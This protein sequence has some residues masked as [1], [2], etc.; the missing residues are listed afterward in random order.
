VAAEWN[1]TVKRGDHMLIQ[2]LFTNADGTPKSMTGYTFWYTAKPAIDADVTDAAALISLDPADFTLD[3]VNGT[4]DRL[5]GLVTE[6]MTAAIVPGT[7]V[8]DLKVKVGGRVSTW[9]DGQLV[10]EGDVSRRAV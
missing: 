3:D 7:L 1:K 4:D 9:L 5:T 6:A 10:V 2:F 8:H